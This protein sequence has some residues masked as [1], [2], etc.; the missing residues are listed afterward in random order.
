MSEDDDTR[1][2]LSSKVA[3]EEIYAR[4]AGLRS[5]QLLSPHLPDTLIVWNDGENG[6]NGNDYALSFQE[7]SGCQ[8]IWDEISDYQATV[9]QNSSL[10]MISKPEY[11]PVVPIE[12]P[13][14]NMAHLD[15]IVETFQN[16]I[17]EDVK[18][19][20][21]TL[22]LENDYISKL[23]DLYTMVTCF[24]LFMPLLHDRLRI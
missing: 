2:L 13:P 22:I 8:E 12:L 5:H 1:T 16:A 11:S 18:P 21:S 6:E 4:Q 20:L 3:A 19:K 17:L 10:G 23:V 9:R 15:E 14:A 24:P 7:A